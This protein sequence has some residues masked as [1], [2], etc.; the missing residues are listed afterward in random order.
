MSAFNFAHSA[1]ASWRDCVEQ[2]ADRLGRPGAGLGFVYFSDALVGEA[3]AIVDVLRSRTGVGDWVGTVGTGIVATGTEY[4]DEPAV[5]A[6]IADL[7]ASSF[8]IFSGKIPMKK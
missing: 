1:G 7:D 6:M 4:Q 3:G 8:G 2:C 5:A